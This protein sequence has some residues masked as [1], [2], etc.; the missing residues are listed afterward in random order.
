MSPFKKI[1]NNFYI[2]QHLKADTNEIFYVGKG[3]KKRAYSHNRGEYWKRVV[4]KHGLIVQIIHQDLDEDTAFKLEIETIQI[5]RSQG[6]KLVNMTDGGE[7]TSGRIT[8]DESRINYSKS[9]L[10]NKNPMYQKTHNPEIIEKIRQASVINH[11]NP[12][13][14]AKLKKAL[15]GINRSDET[16]EKIRQVRTGTKRSDETKKKLSDAKKGKTSNRKGVKLSEETKEKIRLANLGKKLSQETKDKLAVSSKGRVMSDDAKRKISEAN[17]GRVSVRKGK[18]GK[19]LSE[20][21]KEK[22]RQINLGKKLSDETR[23]KM[24]LSRTQS[25]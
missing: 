21:T 12:E 18:P 19:K 1:L 15:T 8:T 13:T 5:Y 23:R 2:Y 7:G 4:A 3:N 14:K 16:K 24:S 22:L 25:N 10:G 17:K 9:R 11:A 20:E 6:I